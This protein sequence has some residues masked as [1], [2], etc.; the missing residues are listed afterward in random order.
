MA[1]ELIDLRRPQYPSSPEILLSA[2]AW[3][4]VERAE[5]T[6]SQGLIYVRH[7]TRK[8]GVVVNETFPSGVALEQYRQGLIE[9]GLH[10]IDG[11]LSMDDARACALALKGLTPEKGAG[12]GSS[13]VGIGV[14]LMQ[15]P[16]GG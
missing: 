16:V 5:P 9:A 6:K 12:T 13:A 2:L 4:M 11:E 1:F 3:S 14:A 8:R 7:G 10:D 15:D